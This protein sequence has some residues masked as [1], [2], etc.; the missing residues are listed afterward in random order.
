MSSYIQWYN[1]FQQ[2]KINNILGTKNVKKNTMFPLQIKKTCADLRVAK[3]WNAIQ[4]HPKGLQF[5]LSSPTACSGSSSRKASKRWKPAIFVAYD[6]TEH[7][8][9]T[10]NFLCRLE[11][12]AMRHW[13]GKHIKINSQTSF[14]IHIHGAFSAEDG[15]VFLQPPPKNVNLCLLSKMTDWLCVFHQKN[16]SGLQ[17]VLRI[18]W[19]KLICHSERFCGKLFLLFCWWKKSGY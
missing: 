15:G 2:K 7:Q 4:S 8:V 1:S 9:W 16:T 18:N 12:Y 3:V 13:K 17:R 10:V 6:I 14:F 11:R 5:L 19:R